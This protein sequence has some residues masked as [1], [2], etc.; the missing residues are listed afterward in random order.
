MGWSLSAKEAMLLKRRINAYNRVVQGWQESGIYSSTPL[1]TTFERELNYVTTKRRYNERMAQLGRALSS[2]KK[3]SNPVVFHGLVVPEYMRNEVRNI[4]RAKNQQFAEMRKT[5]FPQW[6]ILSPQRKLAEMSN[7][8]YYDIDERDYIETPTHYEELIEIEYPDMPKAAEIYIS[9]WEDF[10]GDS[11]IPDIIR[12]LAAKDP[13]GFYNLMESPDKEKDI[14]YIYPSF[15]ET[16][17]GKHYTYKNQSADRTP[18]ADRLEYAAEYWRQ[19]LQ[20]Y[21]NR[22]GYWK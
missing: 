3:A 16:Y 21:Y 9:M 8:N 22:E 17:Y 14:N 12:F 11:D 2:N 18:H 6:D 13:Q 5:Y 1:T 19:Q 7:H 4:S 15:Q 20:D 10:K